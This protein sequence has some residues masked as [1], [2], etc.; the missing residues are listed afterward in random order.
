MYILIDTTNIAVHGT[1]FQTASEAKN[2]AFKL[3]DIG[4]C[5]SFKIT[6]YDEKGKYIE[7]YSS[8]IENKNH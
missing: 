8:K 1:S 7:I 4:L 5:K 3:R 6:K 2:Y